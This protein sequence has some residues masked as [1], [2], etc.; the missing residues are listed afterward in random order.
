MGR[1]YAK[2]AIIPEAKSTRRGAFTWGLETGLRAP[3]LAETGL[4]EA[5]GVRLDR[6][7]T[8]L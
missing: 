5:T 7:F 8:A 1:L 6:G 3:A 2:Q 4:R